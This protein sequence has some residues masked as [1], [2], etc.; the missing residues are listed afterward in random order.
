[1]K[2]VK[3][4]IL[5]NKN[6]LFQRFWQMSLVPKLLIS[7][8]KWFPHCIDESWKWRSWISWGM[9][10][11]ATKMRSSRNARNREDPM[12]R[13]QRFVYC[14]ISFEATFHRRFAVLAL[15]VRYRSKTISSSTLAKH[16]T[17]KC[18]IPQEQQ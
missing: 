9:S 4:S 16:A 5:R 2:Q 6:W 3:T 15:N 8:H 10:S 13:L 14:E 12:E 1:M 7:F 11:F 18:K 17:P